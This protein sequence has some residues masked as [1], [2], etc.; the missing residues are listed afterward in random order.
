LSAHGDPSGPGSI[1]RGKR[2]HDQGCWIRAQATIHL[3][4]G[5]SAAQFDEVAGGCFPGQTGQQIPLL[6]GKSLNGGLRIPYGRALGQ[7]GQ[8]IQQARGRIAVLDC[9]PLVDVTQG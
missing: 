9:E 3:S 6:L 1:R 4:D 5:A 2:R 7:I 8:C